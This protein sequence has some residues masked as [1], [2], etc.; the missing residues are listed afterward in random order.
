MAIAFVQEFEIQGG[1]TSTANYDAVSAALDLKEA[2]DGLF[3]HTAGFDHGS[4]VFRIFDVW[5][6]REQGER[7]MTE[8]LGPIIERMAAD[9]AERGD[10]TFTPPQ[11]E[12]WYELHDSMTG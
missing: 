2:P 9:A 7:F 12:S 6:T 10:E 8:K 1:D 5:A 3:I 11:R 4:G